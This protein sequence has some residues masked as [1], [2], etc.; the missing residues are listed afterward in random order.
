MPS[1]GRPPPAALGLLQPCSV[2]CRNRRQ[3]LRSHIAS[4]AFP[5]ANAL[6]KV[7]LLG[8]HDRFEL[9]VNVELLA[10]AADVIAYSGL[11]DGELLRDL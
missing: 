3:V 6:E 5:E 8:E 2:L 10:D 9:C 1:G 7:V 4:A 11:R